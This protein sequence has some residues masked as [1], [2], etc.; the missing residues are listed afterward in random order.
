LQ[1]RTASKGARNWGLDMGYDAFTFMF[2]ELW[3]DI[4]HALFHKG[5]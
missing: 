3:P 2:H 4:H 1:E 5:S